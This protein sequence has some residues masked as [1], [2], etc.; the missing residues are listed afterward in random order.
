MKQ[1][2]PIDKNSEWNKCFVIQEHFQ[3]K[4]MTRR[5]VIILL[6]LLLIITSMEGMGDG[7]GKTGGNV[8]PFDC[9]LMCFQLMDR[10]SKSL[11]TV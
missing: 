8:N 4:S 5:N 7:G 3:T 1:N 11:C 10:K 2:K 6:L 9:M